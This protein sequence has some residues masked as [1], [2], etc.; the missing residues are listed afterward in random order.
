[1]LCEIDI[2]TFA[3]VTPHNWCTLLSHC[4]HLDYFE[5]HFGALDGNMQPTA[6]LDALALA[7]ATKLPAI[8]HLALGF[9]VHALPHRGPHY[10]HTNHSEH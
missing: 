2:R 5:V 7:I 10:S 4:P 8:E 3:G 9:K 6:D 1:V